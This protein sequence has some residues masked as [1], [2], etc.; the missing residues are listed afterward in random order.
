MEEVT[1]EKAKQAQVVPIVAAALEILE[2]GLGDGA[3]NTPLHRACQ[4]CLSMYL[5]ARGGC[6]SDAGSCVE[7]VSFGPSP[8]KEGDCGRVMASEGIGVNRWPFVGV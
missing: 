5:C 2:A 3:W 6:W 1:A 8:P 7:C 4:V